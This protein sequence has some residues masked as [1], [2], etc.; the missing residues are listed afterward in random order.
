MNKQHIEAD[1]AVTAWILENRV[2]LIKAMLHCLNILGL[3]ITNLLCWRKVQPAGS[4]IR[5]IENSFKEY[6]E[7]SLLYS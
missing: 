5:P 1:C 6:I 3:T 4:T 2:F 7:C